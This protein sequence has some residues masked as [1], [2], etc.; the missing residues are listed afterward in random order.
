MIFLSFPFQRMKISVRGFS[1]YTAS[2]QMWDK[3]VIEDNHHRKHWE[4]ELFEGKY[5]YLSIARAW[6]VL[7]CLLLSYLIIAKCDMYPCAYIQER[8][9]MWVRIGVTTRFYINHWMQRWCLIYLAHCLAQ[10]RCSMYIFLMN[11]WFPPLKKL[12]FCER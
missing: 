10:N 1:L 8:R 12:V 6:E 9:Y 5:N 4:P 11:K 7:V 3:M 2:F